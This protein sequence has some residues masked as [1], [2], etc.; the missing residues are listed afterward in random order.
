MIPSASMD[1]CEKAPP[2]KAS[3]SPSAP[4]LAPA[5]LLNL[6]G[7]MPGNTTCV[8]SRYI[9]MKDKVTM[10]LLFSSSIPQIFLSV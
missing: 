8:H 1:A 6:L 3:I 9:R 10:I 2:A 5:R 7:S 4:V